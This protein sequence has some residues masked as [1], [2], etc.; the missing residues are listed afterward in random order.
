MKYFLT[1]NFKQLFSIFCMS[2]STVCSFSVLFFLFYNLHQFVSYH[3]IITNKTFRTACTILTE[4]LATLWFTCRQCDWHILSP[5][6]HLLSFILL[7]DSLETSLFLRISWTAPRT[8]MDKATTVPVGLLK[9]KV[10]QCI[11]KYVFVPSTDTSYCVVLRCW[12]T[13]RSKG[14][15]CCYILWPFKFSIYPLL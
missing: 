5:R 12:F 1:W 2:S 6:V 4:E 9:E 14:G 10:L 7:A 8:D 11:R 15:C 13:F 3:K